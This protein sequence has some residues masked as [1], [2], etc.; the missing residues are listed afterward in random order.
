MPRIHCPS[1]DRFRSDFLDPQ[2]PVIIEG[3]T[4]HWLAF[5][6]HPWR[7]WKICTIRFDLLKLLHTAILYTLLSI[8][9]L[10]TIAGCRTVPIEVGSK[11][12]D[13]EWS[14]KLITVNDF[15]DRYIIET[16]RIISIYFIV[17]QCFF[18]ALR[19][20]KLSVFLVIFGYFL[21]GRGWSGIS[22]SA[23]VVW[24]GQ[25]LFFLLGAS[26]I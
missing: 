3:I 14:Q 20:C 22:G 2:K 24:S 26:R 19:S 10:R 21:L 4:D 15:I 8:E 11:Y 16:V 13:E 18:F 6:E 17:R 7:Y 12:T 5:T 25:V 23:S 1:L 9:Y